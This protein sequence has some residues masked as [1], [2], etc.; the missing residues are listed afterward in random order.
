MK[1]FRMN[2][3]YY[4]TKKESLG[5]YVYLLE[6]CNGK[7][8]DSIGNSMNMHSSSRINDTVHTETVWFK[9][10]PCTELMPILVIPKDGLYFW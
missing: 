8:S 6:N 10:R 4:I 9:N 5:M 3:D 7:P 2:K 1:S